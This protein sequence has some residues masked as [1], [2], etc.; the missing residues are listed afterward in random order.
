MLTGPGPGKIELDCKKVIIRVGD[1]IIEIK[2]VLYLHVRGWSLAKVTHLDIEYPGIEKI[3][4]LKYREIIG[5][6]IGKIS[7]VCTQV[8]SGTRNILIR[9]FSNDL[10]KLIPDKYYNGCVIGSKIDGIFIGIKKELIKIFEE[11]ASKL[12]YEP[13]R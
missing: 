10:L 13:R 7:N 9:I 6:K 5:A 4:N 11:Y 1:K 3:L 8:K 2:P 12:G